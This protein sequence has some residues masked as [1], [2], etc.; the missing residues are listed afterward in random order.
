MQCTFASYLK[1]LT[2]LLELGYRTRERRKTDRNRSRTD[3]GSG[4][5][6]TDIRQWR[7]RV[8]W[9]EN[10]R[11]STRALH[12]GRWRER[13]GLTIALRALYKYNRAPTRGVRG[14]G[15]DWDPMGPMGFPWEWV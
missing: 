3:R 10:C 8:N 15:E 1:V 12:R 11:R 4:E 13:R 14:N 6:R 9:R 2:V 5:F 7:H